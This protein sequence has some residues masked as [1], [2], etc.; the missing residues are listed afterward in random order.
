MYIYVFVYEN[1][2][3]FLAIYCTSLTFAAVCCI[4]GKSGRHIRFH[5]NAKSLFSMPS[6]T[7][8]YTLTYFPIY[9]QHMHMSTH[10]I[11]SFQLRCRCYFCCKCTNILRAGTKLKYCL[12]FIFSFPIF[13]LDFLLCFQRRIFTLKLTNNLECFWNNNTWNYCLYNQQI[14]CHTLKSI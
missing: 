13:H 9:Q 10:L 4:F 7:Y 2:I 8:I 5:Y 1:G 14:K 6:K 11:H 12:V 3:F